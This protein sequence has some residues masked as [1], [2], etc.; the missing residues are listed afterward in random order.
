[1]GIFDCGAPRIRS[2]GLGSARI[3]SKRSARTLAIMRRRTTGF[4]FDLADA[5]VGQVVTRRVA[6][7]VVDSDLLSA[8]AEL[9][10]RIHITPRGGVDAGVCQRK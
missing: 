9:I 4:R 3:F 7:L 5:Q 8:T 1:L 6:V 10:V 2:S